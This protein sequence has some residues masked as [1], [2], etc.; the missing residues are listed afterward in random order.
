MLPS[1][2]VVALACCFS[3]RQQARATT[4]QKEDIFKKYLRTRFNKSFKAGHTYIVIPELGCGSCSTNALR[5]I[6]QKGYCLNTSL[7][8]SRSIKRISAAE[9]KA[10]GRAV[11]EIIAD[12]TF[13]GINTLDRLQLPFNSFTE[14]VESRQDTVL[15]TAFDNT[16]Y[17]TVL[18]RI[19]CRK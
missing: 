19:S 10:M 2:V 1:G 16:N 8:V 4:T 12:T 13:D 18:D 3:V 5:Y 6:A 11:E 17:E 9:A 7:V 15:Y 14:I